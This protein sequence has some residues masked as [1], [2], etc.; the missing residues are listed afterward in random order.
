MALLLI[1]LNFQYLSIGLNGKSPN[2]Y[3]YA[4]NNP[5]II[6]DPTGQVFFVPFVLLPVLGASL[7]T[8]AYLISTPSDQRTYGGDI[9]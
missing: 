9:I 1:I 2:F 3:V 5:L 8:G 6:K 7:S 4:L